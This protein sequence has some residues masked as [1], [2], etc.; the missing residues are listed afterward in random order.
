MSIVSILLNLSLVAL[1][2]LLSH[3]YSEN[4]INKILY[5]SSTFIIFNLLRLKASFTGNINPDEDQWIFCAMDMSQH[6]INW[7]Q[8]FASSDIIRLFT[9]LPLAICNLFIDIRDYH[10]AHFL[11]VFFLCLF[12]FI[13]E[14]MLRQFFSHKSAIICNGIFIIVFALSSHNDLIDYN[15]EL[16]GI[17]FLEISFLFFIKYFKNIGSQTYQIYLFLG[18]LFASLLPFTKEQTVIAALALEFCVLVILLR[19]KEY[20]SILYQIAGGLLA[21]LFVFSP[22]I[23]YTKWS[24]FGE[25]LLTTMAYAQKGLFRTHNNSLFEICFNMMRNYWFNK[26]SLIL[27]SIALFGLIYMVIYK[28]NYKSTLKGYTEIFWILLFTSIALIYSIYKPQNY[29]YHY[30]IFLFLPC[31]FIIAALINAIEKKK[32]VP[33]LLIIIAIIQSGIAFKAIS[34]PINKSPQ[35]KNT[36]SIKNDPLLDAIKRNVHEQ[37]ITFI[38]GWNNKVFTQFNLRRASRIL[39]PQFALPEY[40]S[41][42]LIQSIIRREVNQNKTKVIIEMV[43]ESRFY[44]SDTLQNIRNV[45]P[46]FNKY[47]HQNFNLVEEGKNYKVFI[48][49]TP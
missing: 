39:Y 9:I 1:F 44:F 31:S 15:S 25:V 18:S 17:L 4:R 8:N 23:I 48:R 47:V 36:F 14:S 27:V 38:W 6:P 7:M 32:I 49:K 34:T 19:K 45:D 37:D 33:Y 42:R 16:S 13:N 26:N 21:L 41:A 24:D 10:F 28:P 20:K 11:T 3:F 12:T 43:G 40:S 22:I 46:A 35:E 2:V 30:A 29:F 5:W